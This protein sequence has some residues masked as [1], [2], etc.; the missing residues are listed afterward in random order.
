[1]KLYKTTIQAIYYFLI[2]FVSYTVMNKFL[3]LKSFQINLLKT[4]VFGNN[5]TIYLSYFVIIVEF[6]V[7][8]FL[9]FN[10]KFGT[11]FMIIMLSVFTIYISFLRLY[12]RYEVCGCGGILNGLQFKYHLIIN[13][14]LISFS[15]LIYNSYKKSNS[16]EN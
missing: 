15:Y 3:A 12:G 13:I 2:V 10:K 14:L 8:L 11:L 1:M 7:L 6:L 9:V 5:T 16:N 4:G